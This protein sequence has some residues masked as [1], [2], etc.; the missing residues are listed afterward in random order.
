MNFNW[1]LAKQANDKEGHKRN[2]CN[3]PRRPIQVQYLR[4]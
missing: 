1:D 4:S 2:L 3:C